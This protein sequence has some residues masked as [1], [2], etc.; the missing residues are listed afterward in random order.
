[1]LD[2]RILT[3][4]RQVSGLD[5]T[6]SLGERALRQRLANLA[7]GDAE[8][9]VERLLADDDELALLVDQ[10]VVPETWFFR[11]PAAFAHA[12]QHALQLWRGRGRRVR[13]LSLPCSS[14]EEAYSLAMA[15][16]DAG[17][18]PEAFQI[19]ALDISEPNLVKA[20][21]ALYGR[22]S[23]RGQPGDFRPRYFDTRD[24]GELLQERVRRLVDFAQGNLLHL[25]MQG[26][27]GLYDIL[28]CRNLLIYFD[29]QSQGRAIANLN[30]LLA[31]DGLLY[32]GSS[33]MAACTRHGFVSAGIP[34][35]S[36]MHKAGQAT[37]L[38]PRQP[39]A[40][41]VRRPPATR[42]ATP[43]LARPAPKAPAAVSAVAPAGET[44]LTQARLLADNGH[45]EAAES[46]LQ[47]ALLLT[48]NCAQGFFLLGLLRESRDPAEADQCLRRA[49][50]LDPNHYEALCHLAVLVER[51]GDGLEASRLRQRA[52]R[53][54][55]RQE[56]AG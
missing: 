45:L 19:E 2:P 20:R 52:A 30:G 55:R 33:E 1:M 50:Y 12:A 3:R 22:N 51:R 53:V 27:M 28:F 17:L 41:K 9:Y 4:I 47:Q 32:T 31:E 34:W 56:A 42:A 40:A 18:E 26:R 39:G 36:A 10:I 29:E 24:G 7:V 43:A 5:M 49:V 44:L 38:E 13:L 8:R 23:F 35:A 15:L 11:E 25:D 48:P 21:Q 54:L 14:G 6:S 16:L 46:L 37:R